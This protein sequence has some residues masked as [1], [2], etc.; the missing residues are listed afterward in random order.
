[1]CSNNDTFKCFYDIKGFD[2]T[3]H[4]VYEKIVFILHYNQ[5]DLI[6]KIT[7]KLSLCNLITVT[8]NVADSFYH[9]LPVCSAEA[10]AVVFSF[11]SSGLSFIK[12]Q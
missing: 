1:M 7:H 3:F 4:Y 9:S 10:N 8:I 5:W 12:V 6:G 2:S 11:T